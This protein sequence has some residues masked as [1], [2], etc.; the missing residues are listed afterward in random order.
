[1]WDV[2]NI[3]Q[4]QWWWVFRWRLSPLCLLARMHVWPVSVKWA[5]LAQTIE[6]LSSHVAPL[7]C[8]M[9]GGGVSKGEG[10]HHEWTGGSK[11]FTHD[12]ELPALSQ[13]ILE[14]EMWTHRNMKNLPKK[15]GAVWTAGTWASHETSS[16]CAAAA[17]S[18][19][20]LCWLPTD[21]SDS[22]CSSGC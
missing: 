20:D 16:P 6:E 10:S 7:I 18:S 4:N 2:G 21:V 17:V 5:R 19:L 13:A 12:F 11:K 14:N 1:M 9:L 8:I 22:V 15:Q 3:F